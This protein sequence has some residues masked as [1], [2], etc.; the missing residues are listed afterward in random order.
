MMNKVEKMLAIVI[1]MF[2]GCF[3]CFAA[4]FEQIFWVSVG[5]TLL[6]AAAG[7]GLLF[8][9]SLI[10]RFLGG[11]G[12]AFVFACYIMIIVICIINQGFPA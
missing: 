8:I 3:S 10:V 4:S 2:V 12:V 5:E 9:C 6:V 11:I 7:I 1:V